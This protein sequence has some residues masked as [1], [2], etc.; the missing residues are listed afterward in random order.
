VTGS[1]Q[2]PPPSPA[3]IPPAEIDIDERLVRALLQS[4]HPDLADLPLGPAATGWD[5]ATYRL[6]DEL[7]VR[8]PRTGDAVPPLC[9]EQEWLPRL[10][11]RLP[12]A[13]PAP[14]RRG[15][16]AA[17]YPWPWSVVAWTPGRS[18]DH[19]QL[20]PAQASRF[21]RFLA[22][23]HEPASYTFP[24][25]DYR[26][27]PLARVDTI[28]TERLHRLSTIS[29]GLA[30]P[31]SAV[32]EQWR[33]AAAASVDVLD[34]CVHGDLHPKNL[35]VDEGRLAAVLDWGDLTAGDP[36]IDL[37]AAWMLFPPD[38]HASFWDAYRPVGPETRLRAS[39]WAVFFGLMLLEVGL[40]GDPPFAEIGRRTLAR[41]VEASSR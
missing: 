34:T 25:N 4:Q 18:A 21:G 2:N 29:T 13:V 14:V 32:R 27:V 35:V 26:G 1:V 22:A 7:A 31:L 33:R 30:V 10:A 19:E 15:E 38:A 9:R 24:R 36:A 16:P 11:P 5:N 39:G 28:V 17:G 41:V 6:G 23:L 40:A 12:V 20:S 8:L 3:G 37:G